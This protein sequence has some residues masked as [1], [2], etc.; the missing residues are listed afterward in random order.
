M[1]SFSARPRRAAAEA[2]ARPLLLDASAGALPLLQ[3]STT[4][5]TARRKRRLPSPSSARRHRRIFN[6]PAALRRLRARWPGRDQQL[7]AL[8]SALGGP[9]DRAPHML[10]HG[11][12]ATGKTSIVR[13]ET[14]CIELRRNS[15]IF[16]SFGGN[17]KTAPSTFVLFQ[18]QKNASQRRP[19]RARPQDRLRRLLLLGPAASRRQGRGRPAARRAP[20]ALARLW[21]RDKGRPRRRLRP[22]VLRSRARGL[23]APFLRYFR[24]CARAAGKGR[25]RGGRPDP[26]RRGHRC[27]QPGRRRQ[28]QRRRRRQQKNGADGPGQPDA[29]LRLLDGLGRGRLRARDL[30]LPSSARGGVP[31]LLAGA[32]N[33]D[34]GARRARRRGGR[35]GSGRR[36]GEERRRGGR[37]DGTPPTPWPSSSPSTSRCSAGPSSRSLA[38]TR[39]ASPT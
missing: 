36:R 5:R 35:G 32:G 14:D 29:H 10:V 24:R 31:A 21:A 27:K 23:A 37:Q 15:K 7:I 30:R 11:P 33:D 1:S 25:G 6:A 20:K 19:R 26:S 9:G 13:C 34:L 4:T 2:P 38:A 22:S 12:Q 39:S 3:Q 28:R 17:Q 18:K 8:L 16:I